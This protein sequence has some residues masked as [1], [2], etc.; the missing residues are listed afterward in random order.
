[1]TIKYLLLLLLIVSNIIT[2]FS[3]TNDR[4][5]STGPGGGTAGLS[6][7]DRALHSSVLNIEQA[8]ILNNLSQILNYIRINQIYSST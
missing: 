8:P 4:H 3:M 1:M 7:S 2:V 5:G 6:I